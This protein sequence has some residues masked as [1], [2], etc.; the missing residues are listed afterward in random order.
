M[1]RKLNFV[2]RYLNRKFGPGSIGAI[3][4]WV[5]EYNAIVAF[6]S[7]LIGIAI[8]I[9]LDNRVLYYC[10]CIIP[11]INTLYSIDGILLLDLDCEEEEEV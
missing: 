3:G 4:I 2:Y 11:I 5:L 8:H 6:I 7:M 9:L 10:T 1:R